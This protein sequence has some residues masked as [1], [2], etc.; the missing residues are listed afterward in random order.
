MQGSNRKLACYLP[1]YFFLFTKLKKKKKVIYIG[2]KKM[3]WKAVTLS[4]SSFLYSAI[5]CRRC[6]GVCP[7][8]VMIKC[9]GT[10][11]VL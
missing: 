8:F 11:V 7:G 1:Y 4:Q 2:V 10:V 6:E 3:K 9:D 5:D